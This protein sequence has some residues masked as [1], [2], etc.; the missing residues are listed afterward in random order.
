V[1]RR[2]RPIAD[3]GSEAARIEEEVVVTKDG[4]Q[5]ITNSLSDRLISCGLP[6]CEVL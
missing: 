3:L 2:S 4:C 6:G 5:I 1:T